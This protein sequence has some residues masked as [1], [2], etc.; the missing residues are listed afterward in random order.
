MF[1]RGEPNANHAAQKDVVYR[2]T[3]R[4]LVLAVGHHLRNARVYP[5]PTMRVPRKRTRRYSG[6]GQFSGQ[7]KATEPAVRP[8]RHDGSHI[9][10]C[11]GHSTSSEASC[12]GRKTNNRGDLCIA[13]QMAGLET[14]V[15]E[16]LRR[17]FVRPRSSGVRRGQR[18]PLPVHRHIY[19]KIFARNICRVL[20]VG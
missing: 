12:G 3:T 10:S 14:A 20:R 18:G 16:R 2:S 15:D 19:V 17:C 9:A 4:K 1:T 5:K 13:E 11:C 7:N 6:K 8:Q